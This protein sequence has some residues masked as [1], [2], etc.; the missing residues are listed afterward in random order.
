MG[1]LLIRY[2]VFVSSLNIAIVESLS[3]GDLKIIVLLEVLDVV[4][5]EVE[6]G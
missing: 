2:S 1:P 4:N 3:P 5:H 6:R